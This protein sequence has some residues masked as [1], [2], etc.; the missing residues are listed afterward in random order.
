MKKKIWIAIAGVVFIFL[1]AL[2][3]SLLKSKNLGST[4]ASLPNDGPIVELS[5]K[6]LQS[7]DLKTNKLPDEIA[8]KMTGKVKLPGFVVPLE[9]KIDQT[10]HFL[11]VPNQAYCV[12]VPPP[13]ANL[14]VE[15]NSKETV[16]NK[17]QQGPIWLEGFIT[18]ENGQTQFGTAAWQFKAT[19]HYPYELAN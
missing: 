7:L 8:A 16:L 5:W 15:V 18:L 4:T 19:T 3:P 12:H 10:T 11:F 9:T 6:D 14:M 2:I 13:P 1:G 17:E